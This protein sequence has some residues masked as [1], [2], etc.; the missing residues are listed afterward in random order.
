MNDLILMGVFACVL[1]AAI[2]T[3]IEF[4]KKRKGR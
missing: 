2:W 1:I 4:W 3:A